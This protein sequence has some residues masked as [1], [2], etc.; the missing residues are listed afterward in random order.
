VTDPDFILADEPTGNLDAGS[1]NDVLGLLAALNDAH[2]KTILMVTHDPHAARY[3]KTTRHL[4]KGL[5]LPEG[6][7]SQDWVGAHIA[8]AIRDHTGSTRTGALRS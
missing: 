1:A 5:L 2:G 8:G 6:Q 3:A 4:D 7:V